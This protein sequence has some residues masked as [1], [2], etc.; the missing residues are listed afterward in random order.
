M[1]QFDPVMS[2]HLRSISKKEVKD[3]YFSKTIQNELIVLVG[4][5]KMDAIVQ[6][7]KE[8][9]YIYMIMDWTPDKSQSTVA[10]AMYCECVSGRAVTSAT[11]WG[12]IVFST[13]SV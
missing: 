13:E 5:K 2:E 4:Q 7:L 6:K 10:I 12:N 1:A 9:K 11:I 3:H 8:A